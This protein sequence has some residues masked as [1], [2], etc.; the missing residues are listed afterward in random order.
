MNMRLL[1]LRLESFKGIK[2]FDA[3][4]DGENAVIKSKNGV[5]KTT[6]YDA[7]LWLLFGKDSTGRAEF[8]VR[9][10]D[11][12]N[13]LIKGLTLTVSATI[14]I[15]GMPHTFRKQH[16]EKTVKRQFRG[17]E[18][19]CWIDEVPKKVGEYAEYIKELI[20]EDTFKLLTDLHHFNS[21]FHWTD[22]RAIL[23]DI[24]GEIGTPDGF[25]ALLGELN[26][27]TIE[28]YKKVLADQKKRL[29][30]ERDEINPRIDEIQR[31][32]DEYVG[33]DS[34]DVEMLTASRELIKKEIAALDEKRQ[35]I[36]EQEKQRQASLDKVNKLKSDKAKREV[37]LAS[38][39][40]GIQALLGEK[41]KLEAELSKK[42]IALGEA[43]HF[44]QAN[45]LLI[46]YTTEQLKLS[47]QSLAE[48]KEQYHKAKD[49]PKND[50]CYACGQTLPNEM[51]A[52]LEK[53]RQAELAE[54]TVKG[55]RELEYNK[56]YKAALIELEEKRK[57]LQL[58]SAKTNAEF[59][60]A[61][62]NKT[63]RFAEIDEAVKNRPTTPPE[64]DPQW[65]AICE[66]IEKLEAE[67]GEPVSVQLDAIDTARKEKADELATV[68]NCLAQSDTR[69]K[70][71][72]R[73]GELERR[74]KELA[75]CIAR[76][77]KLLNDIDEY[78]AAESS[79]IESAV[80]GMFKHVEFKLFNTLQNGSVED[81]CE[82]TL[83]GVPYPDMSTGQKIIVG[84]DIINVLSAHYE[85]SVPLFVDNAESLTFPLEANS[86][87]IEL[88]AQKNINELTLEKKKEVAHVI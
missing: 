4:F 45:A 62:V 41:N 59:E 54:I 51:L 13:Q 19:L 72:Q 53:K 21:K 83:N 64:K 12:N 36:F 79:L 58:A 15:D 73:I 85:L 39:T 43:V 65:L 20:P 57:A 30:K 55:T 14:E 3:E 28:E 47:M 8:S 16:A 23:L 32:L 5:G 34:N 88:F 25:D 33:T 38:D 46:K 87:T 27:R 29:V 42:Q 22:R 31:G 56:S 37:A 82:A 66:Q 9:P 1:K 61:K 11:K 77:E 71:N 68:N 70:S 35:V 17:Y 76:I 6:I 86:Q 60:Q 26:G 48:A 84:I 10:L 50:T 40:S 67:I 18:T 7:F 80:N 24:A 78:K 44:V 81:C 2:Q 63:K 75:E 74:E 69:A 52:E 49:A